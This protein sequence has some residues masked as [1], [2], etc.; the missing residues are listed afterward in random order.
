M[1]I[2]FFTEYKVEGTVVRESVYIAPENQRWESCK[3]QSPYHH[4]GRVSVNKISYDVSASRGKF[5]IIYFITHTQQQQLFPSRTQ[6]RFF[7][8]NIHDRVSSITLQTHAY[9]AR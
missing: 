3:P 5:N 1:E 2:C 9:Q 6:K 8:W 4:V 7:P